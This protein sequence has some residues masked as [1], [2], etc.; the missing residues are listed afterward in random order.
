LYRL[1][2]EQLYF[3]KESS[4][5]YDK[6]IEIEA[7]RL[8]GHIR[9]L[10][11]DSISKK[12]YDSSLLTK[13]SELKEILITNKKVDSSEFGTVNGLVQAVYSKIE[14]AQ[15]EQ[16][17]SRS[18]L[19][20]MDMKDRIKYLDTAIN[21]KNAFAFYHFENCKNMTIGAGLPYA[22]LLSKKISGFGFEKKPKLIFQPL[23]YQPNF[24][25]DRYP[26]IDFE[27]WWIGEIYDNRK[28]VTLRRKDIIL[29][30]TNQEGFAHVGDSVDYKYFAYKQKNV[31]NLNVNGDIVEFDNIPVYATVR[32]IVFEFTESLGKVNFDSSGR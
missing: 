23:F 19:T 14:Q 17:T 18:L 15:K 1:L 29:N 16:I 28:G 21:D 30:V 6:G 24:T 10:L 11:H 13:I 4:H 20:L 26:F 7:V 31:L 9:T 2:Q 12:E 27:S 8:A 22:G 32:Q 25:V 5:E 3:L